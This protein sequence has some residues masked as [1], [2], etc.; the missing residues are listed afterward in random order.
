MQG[1]TDNDDTLDR[2]LAEER[3]PP[4]LRRSRARGAGLPCGEPPTP[5]IHNLGDPEDVERASEEAGIRSQV[6]YLLTG[7]TCREPHCQPSMA[8]LP[9]LQEGQPQP[10]PWAGFD[11]ESVDGPPTIAIGDLQQPVLPSS[12]DRERIE[13][14]SVGQVQIDT[15]GQVRVTEGEVGPWALRR[16]FESGPGRQSL[17]ER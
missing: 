17:V 16:S 7:M 6:S 4:S 5:K 15:V 3:F 1:M 10:Q 12:V 2:R 11:Y 13:S 14:G 8:M 9:T